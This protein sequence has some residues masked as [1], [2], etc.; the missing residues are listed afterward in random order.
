MLVFRTENRY[1]QLQVEFPGGSNKSVVNDIDNM[2]PIT[3][4]H[5]FVTYIRNS[6]DIIKCAVFLGFFW[7]V[8]ATY[9]DPYHQKS[10]SLFSDVSSCV[11]DWNKSYKYIFTWL[12]NWIIH[13]SV[14]GLCSTRFL[15]YLKDA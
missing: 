6:L 1:Q 7:M 13:L 12:F 10:N 3:Y 9:N 11:L 2:T 5:D 14:A 4:S 8:N 15:K